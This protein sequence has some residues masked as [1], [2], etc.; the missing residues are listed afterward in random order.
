MRHAE[1]VSPSLTRGT[2]FWF[3]VSLSVFALQYDENYS[4]KTAQSFQHYILNIFSTG[5]SVTS[6][7][8][9]FIHITWPIIGS[10]LLKSL[11]LNYD[12]FELIQCQ[13]TIFTG[14]TSFAS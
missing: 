7:V 9:E 6:M 14:G 12:F 3:V 10:K 2:I 13:F 5:D 4:I 8:V 11:Q 1:V